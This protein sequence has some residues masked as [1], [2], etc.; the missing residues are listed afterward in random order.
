MHLVITML[1]LIAVKNRK[2]GNE[3]ITFCSDEGLVLSDVNF[4]GKNNDASNTFTFVSEVHHSVSWL[5]HCISNVE[6]HNKISSMEILYSCT[7]SDHFLRA[8]PLPL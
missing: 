5:D 6:G 8:R 4:L 1:I 3:L 2:F 7:G